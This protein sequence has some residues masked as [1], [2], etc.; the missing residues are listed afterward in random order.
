M[1][2]YIVDDDDGTRAMLAE[3][4]EDENLGLVVGESENGSMLDEQ[5]FTLKKTDI[6]LIDLLMPIKDG[7][8]TIRDIKPIFKGKIIMVSQIET[9]ELIAQ[10][11]SH[12]VSYF[13]T[14][15]INK[16]E[17]SSVIRNVIENIN[18]QKSVHSIHQLAGSI[19][20]DHPGF[21][22]N[23]FAEADHTSHAQ[24][25]LSELSILGENGYQDLLDIV[26]YLFK[27]ERQETFK[28]GIPHL[29]D[30]FLK[31]AQE[32]RESHLN[33]KN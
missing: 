7:I 30:I 13:I 26:D 21:K 2:F 4:I 19:L 18:M 24:F 6:L 15:P 16:I 20:L 3:I 22:E 8:E 25:L 12:G 5:H 28:N 31:V 14:K 32:K 23:S 33:Q 29:K 17:V 9:K 1:L 10:A 11:Y 27:Y